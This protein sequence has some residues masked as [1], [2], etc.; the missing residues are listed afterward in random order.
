VTEDI[1][2]PSR[3]ILSRHQIL[4]CDVLKDLDLNMSKNLE[5]INFLLTYYLLF[6]FFYYYNNTINNN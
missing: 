2:T 4:H 3:R 1:P 6:L 5:N